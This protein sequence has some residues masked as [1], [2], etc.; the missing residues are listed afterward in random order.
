MASA[1][2]ALPS[3]P[4]APSAAANKAEPSPQKPDAP[5]T[6]TERAQSTQLLAEA[7]ALDKAG[8]TEQAVVK[9]EAAVQSDP[10]NADTTMALARGQRL[11]NQYEKENR[12]LRKVIEL[13][14]THSAALMALGDSQLRLRGT[15]K[16]TVDEAAN[17][18]VASYK[19]AS[20]RKAVLK[21]LRSREEED[22]TSLS[23]AAARALDLIDAD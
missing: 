21:A 8:K 17:Y 4:S 11:T 6:A 22:G 5:T 1:P 3:P 12:T 13:Q 2:A 16:K 14:P 7:R 9:L 15:D 20:D 18:Y 10:A 19:N 23:L